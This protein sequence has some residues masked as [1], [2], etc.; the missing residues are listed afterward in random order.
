[1]AHA[2]ALIV[3][4]TRHCTTHLQQPPTPLPQA[5]PVPLSAFKFID[6]AV[7]GETLVRCLAALFAALNGLLKV[8]PSY[9]LCQAQT[10]HT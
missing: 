3:A 8:R 10:H 1:V 2:T 6:D 4:A 9:S 5:P 7:S